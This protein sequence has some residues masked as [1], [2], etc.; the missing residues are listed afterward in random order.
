MADL[1]RFGFLDLVLLL[2]VLSAAAGLRV[3][4]LMSCADKSRSSGPLRVQ[5]EPLPEQEALVHNLAHNHSFSSKAPFSAEEEHTAHVSPG[6]PSSL[7]LLLRFVGEERL[8][9]TVR[10]AQAGLGSLT[11]VFWFLFARRSFRSLFVGTLAGLLCALHPFWIIDT[12]ALDDGVLTSFLLAFAVMLGSRAGET[13]GP[14]P[15]LLYGFTLAGLSLV[16]AA[17]LPFAFLST[18]W[19]LFRTRSLPGGWLAALVALL[20]FATGL[21]PWTVRNLQVFGE[22][23]PVVSSAWLHLWVGN[24]PTATGGPATEETWTQSSTKELHATKK[25]TERYNQLAPRVWREVT[26]HPDTALQ[27]R[28]GAALAFLFGERWL[29]DGLLAEPTSSDADFPTWLESSYAVALQA[30]L[31]GMLVLAFLGWRWTYGWRREAFPATLALL[32]VPFPYILSHAE[33]LSGPRLPLD[34]IL[35]CLAAFALATFNPVVRAAL[36]AGPQQQASERRPGGPI[37]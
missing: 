8:P 36:L 1:R 5:D 10:L 12:A 13:G 24:N 27:R 30:W 7:A 9:S 23:V 33:N 26:T 6:Y 18:I 3:G 11:C 14:F 19:F 20:S 34:G 21:A 16:R 15:S 4:Y 32:W 22:P 25:Q 17:M 2:V 29:T 31:G 28:W 35:L 37:V